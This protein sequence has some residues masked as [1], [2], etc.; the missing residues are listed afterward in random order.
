MQNT[1]QRALTSQRLLQAA[2]KV[3]AEHGYRNARIRDICKRANANVAAV[4]YHYRDKEQLYRAVIENAFFRLNADDPMPRLI[5]DKKAA[6]EQQLYGFVRTLLGQLLTEGP[7]SIYA[8]LI[9]RELVDPTSALDQVIDKG[10]APQI[11]LLCGIIRSHVGYNWS[12]QSVRRTATSILGQ[13]LF[14]Y[15]ARPVID[16][17]HIENDLSPLGLDAIAKH[18][19]QF[20]QAALSSIPKS[21]VTPK[22]SLA[23]DR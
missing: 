17:L 16:R 3:F 13:C 23:S 5:T 19:T 15:F 4:N 7:S 14:Y 8:R 10:I 18:I 6:F 21:I 1:P 9:A 12:E 11:E 20:T 2:T 22:L